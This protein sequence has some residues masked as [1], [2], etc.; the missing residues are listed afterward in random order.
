VIVAASVAITQWFGAHDA[1][2]AIGALCETSS[3]C[4]DP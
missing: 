4:C 3:R 2:G 1:A